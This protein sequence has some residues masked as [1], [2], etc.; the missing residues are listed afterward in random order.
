MDPIIS[1]KALRFVVLGAGVVGL[2]TALTLKRAFPLASLKIISKYFPGDRTIEYTSP[3]AGANWL[4]GATDNGRLEKFDKDTYLRFEELAGAIP[5][6]G[7]AKL[8]L[9]A[10]FNLTAAEAGI[11]SNDTKEIWYKSLVGGIDEIPKEELPLGAVYGMDVKST[12][13]INVPVYLAW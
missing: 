11:L 13:V 5:E 4:S 7:L 9:R 8:P 2:S 3:W 6:C 1:T 10:F 12:F